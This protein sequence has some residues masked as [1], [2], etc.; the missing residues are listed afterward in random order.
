M[1]GIF[2]ALEH[3]SGLKAAIVSDGLI[4][5]GDAIALAAENHSTLSA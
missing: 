5:N 3:R 2:K 4:R 1:K